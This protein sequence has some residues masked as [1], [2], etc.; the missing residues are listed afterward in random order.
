MILL[1]WMGCV[2]PSDAG[3]DTAEDTDTAGPGGETG[4]PDTADT[5]TADTDTDTA[6]DTDTETG[7][8]APLAGALH[9]E[10]TWRGAAF[11]VDCTEADGDSV[12]VRYWSD[13]LGN[14][15]GT[16]ACYRGEDSRPW[17][18]VTFSRAATGDWTEPAEATWMIGDGA[19][20]W[21]YGSG[22]STA[23]ALGISRFE[24]L[25]LQTYAIAGT[26]SGVWTAEDGG[27]SI[28]GAFD[29]LLPC[30]GACP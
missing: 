16:V 3:A 19:G 14:V 13:A 7:D 21:G 24:R 22:G 2:A 1:V 6:G 8:P 18:A 9:V 26:L 5:D 29:A 23:W 28:T 10:G 17:A 20:A 25:D 4:H 12:F 27:G 15:A 30:S 11:A